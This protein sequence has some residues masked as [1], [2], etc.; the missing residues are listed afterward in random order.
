MRS[1]NIKTGQKPDD[2][3]GRDFVLPPFS[4]DVTTNKPEAKRWVEDGFVWC[5]AFNHSEGERCFEKAIEIDPECA[6]AY[7]GLAFALGPN[8][9]KPWKAFD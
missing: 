3:E 1:D 5:Y 9:N 2:A 4:R 7:W 8:Y 6:L